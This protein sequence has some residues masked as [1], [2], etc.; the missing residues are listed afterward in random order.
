MHQTSVQQAMHLV[1]P[2]NIAITLTSSCFSV[3]MTWDVIIAHI[4]VTAAVSCSYPL[5]N[6][7]RYT[8]EEA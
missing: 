7:D 1:P 5:R 8:T 6:W 2:S 3:P 4:T